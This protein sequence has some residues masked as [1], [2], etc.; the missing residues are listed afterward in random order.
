MNK[1]NWEHA[2]YAA[3]MF[4]AVFILTG[5]NYVAASLFGIAFFLGREHAQ[6]QENYKWGD[7]EAFKFWRWNIDALFDL[8]FPVVMCAMLGFFAYVIIFWR[9]LQ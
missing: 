6:A 3:I 4:A 7:F 5:F 8:I 1:T 2:G 9:L